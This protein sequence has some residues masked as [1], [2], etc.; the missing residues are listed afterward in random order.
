MIAVAIILQILGYLVI[1]K[2]IRIRV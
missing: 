2:I 1:R